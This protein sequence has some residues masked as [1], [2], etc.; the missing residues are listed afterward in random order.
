MVLAS[1]DPPKDDPHPRIRE[2]TAEAEPTETKTGA[3][4][5]KPT[6]LESDESDEDGGFHSPK[7]IAGL[8][9]I[10]AQL[11]HDSTTTDSIA[12]IVREE[13]QGGVESHVGGV[14]QRTVRGEGASA[15][16]DGL[17]GQYLFSS[18]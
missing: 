11:I 12:T 7:F 15:P 1:E 14:A 16:S 9:A 17:G 4:Y 2:A 13:Q 8:D 5:T 18:L 10:H 3:N 6:E